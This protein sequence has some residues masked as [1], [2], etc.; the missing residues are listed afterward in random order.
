MH[1]ARKSRIDFDEDTV[2]FLM[3]YSDK[4]HELNTSL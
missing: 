2:P 1:Q 3:R 4:V